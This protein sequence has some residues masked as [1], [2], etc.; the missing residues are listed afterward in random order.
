M[1][2]SLITSVKAKNDACIVELFI[3]LFQ[4]RSGPVMLVNARHFLQ[5]VLDNTSL[6][7][8][9]PFAGNTTYT[10]SRPCSFLPFISCYYGAQAWGF[11]SANFW[12]DRFH[13]MCICTIA[14][15]RMKTVLQKAG[16][17]SFPTAIGLFMQYNGGQA[18]FFVLYRILGDS[19]WTNRKG[20]FLW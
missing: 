16:S 3:H 19:S 18:Q 7:Q 11:W 4:D 9:L 1:R 17:A 13:N 10:N 20:L 5:P 6:Q 15:K 12:P 8:Q 14:S 2:I